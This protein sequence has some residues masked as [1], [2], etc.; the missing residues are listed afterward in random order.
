MIFSVKSSVGCIR[1]YNQDFYHVPAKD[2]I[3]FFMVADGMGGTK[4][5]EIASTVAVSTAVT[6]IED[7][8]SGCTD[9][10]LLLRSA[11]NAANGAVYRMSRMDTELSRMGTTCTAAL[12]VDN[13]VYVAQVGDSRAYILDESGFRQLTTDHSYVQKLVQAG[14]ITKEMARLHPDRNKIT[15][16]VG[17][18]GYV[19]TDINMAILHNE[20]I[21]MLCSDGLCT[22][23]PDSEIEQQLRENSPQ[24]S[25]EQLVQLA[26]RAGGFDNITVIVIKNSN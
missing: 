9:Y 25:A 8:F 4:G 16:A 6:F 10:P 14:E 1:E 23:L 19:S 12:I 5:G 17:V 11:V 26:E 15:R 21:L 3:P 22:M 13:V 2:G 7:N 24:K 18:K 20:A